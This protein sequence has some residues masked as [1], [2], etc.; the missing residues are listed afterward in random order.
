MNEAKI[1][2]DYDCYSANV[3]GTKIYLGEKEFAVFEVLLRS[4]GRCVSKDR[5]MRYADI[6]APAAKYIQLLRK[7]LGAD[8]IRT[9]YKRGYTIP[10][11]P[12]A[13]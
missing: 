7:K 11:E 9:I 1:A 2:L 4:R 6:K 5:V 12:H 13:Q 8:C 10:L 3:N